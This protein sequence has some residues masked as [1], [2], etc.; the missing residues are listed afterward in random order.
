MKFIY[1]DG[2]RKEA[3]YKGTTGD[4][5]VRAISIATQKPYQEIYDAIN[6]LGEREH[7]G[8]RKRGKSNARTG[9]YKYAIKKYMASIGWKWKP[10]MFIGSG[11]QV[12]LKE[13]ELPKGRLLVTV[14]RHEVAV[15]DG[16]MHD[17]FD[18]S[19]G[20]TRCVYGYYYL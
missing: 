17:T 18:H 20:G 15:I 9:V 12:H 13:D 2:G 4:C 8:R 3:G 6:L 14:S 5:V 1:N 16:V 19:R 10:T 11:C 7:T